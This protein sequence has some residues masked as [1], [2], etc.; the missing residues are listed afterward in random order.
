M[1]T[2]GALHF[3]F[4]ELQLEPRANVTNATDLSL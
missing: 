2:T 4:T 3:I 1:S